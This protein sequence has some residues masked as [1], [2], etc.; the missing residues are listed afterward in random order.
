MWAHLAFVLAL[1]V[2]GA[3]AYCRRLWRIANENAEAAEH[4]RLLLSEVRNEVKGTGAESSIEL[5]VAEG[6]SF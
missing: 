5:I 3:L 1:V 4:C 2:A 6:G